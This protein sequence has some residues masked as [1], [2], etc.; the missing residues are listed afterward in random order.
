MTLFASPSE[1]WKLHSEDT[2]VFGEEQRLRSERIRIGKFLGGDVLLRERDLG[3]NIAE[4]GVLSQ[5]G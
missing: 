1:G 4:E 2:I 5:S 3:D